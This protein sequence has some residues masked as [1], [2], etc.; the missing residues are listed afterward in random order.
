MVI[1]T[2]PVLLESSDLSSLSQDVSKK[3][4]E[5]EVDKALQEMIDRL[6]KAAAV[7]RERVLRE[8]SK[9]QSRENSL[10]PCGDNNKLC[11]DETGY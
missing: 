10:E 7:N 9:S 5:M 1:V 6:N 2:A 4:E 8:K 11:T 3:Q